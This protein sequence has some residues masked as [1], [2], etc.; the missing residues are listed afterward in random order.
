MAQLFPFYE[1]GTRNDSNVNSDRRR[2][3]RNAGNEEENRGRKRK[4]KGRK[5][6]KSEKDAVNMQSLDAGHVKERWCFESR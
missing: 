5:V 1:R 4:K 3:L 6:E 2:K